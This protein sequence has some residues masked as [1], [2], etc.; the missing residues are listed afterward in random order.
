MKVSIEKGRDLLMRNFGQ[1]AG[2]LAALGI[3]GFGGFGTVAEAAQVPGPA[4]QEVRTVTGMKT[5]GIQRV[6]TISQVYG[7]GEKP[8]AVVL[9]YPAALPAGSLSVQDFSVPGKT[10]TAVYTSDKPELTTKNVSGRYA[11]LWLAQEN[12]VSDQP[13]G[14]KQPKTADGADGK[15]DGNHGRD[16]KDA[17][18]NSN[19]QMPELSL[20]VRQTGMVKAADG[21]IYA[22]MNQE[23]GST[24][25]L[26]PALQGFNLYE[27]TDSKTGYKIP[28][29]LYLPR[30][31]DATKKYPL[32]FFVADASANT[33]NPKMVL[34]Q[35]N[36]AAVWADPVEQA[37]HP[38]IILAPAY[39]QQLV[40]SL[41][42]LTDDSN[43]WT[44]GLT[45]VSDLLFDV[46]DR[47]SV[48]KDRVYGTGQ[49]QGGMTNI[50]ISDKYPELF[51]A[52]YLVAC[53]WNPVEMEALKDKNLWI[54][55][56]QGDTKAYPGMNEAVRR[57]ENLG[58]RVAASNFW[59]SRST[60]AEFAALVKQI[61]DQRAKI[62]YTVFAGGNHMYTWSVAYTIEGIR[63][64]LFAQQ[65]STGQAALNAR[66]VLSKAALDQGIAYYQGKGV[67]QDYSRALAYFQMADRQGNFKAGRYIGLCYENG[68]GVPVDMKKAVEW[69]QKAAA[70]GDITGTC[71]LGHMYED[72]L[73]VERDYSK[74]LQLYMQSARRGDVIAAPGMVSAGRLFEKGLGVAR[75]I[76]LAKVYYIQALSTGYQA[77]QQDL[78]RI[79]NMK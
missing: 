56:C 51:A 27:Y 9:E 40:N 33:D 77:A 54:M 53:Q 47:Y 8:A 10:I 73:G 58:S 5:A 79:Q 34:V 75:D 11:V 17:P 37:K 31:Y 76:T 46:M 20:Q 45:L 62:N 39:T 69:Y 1:R 23:L 64:W 16:G 41:D 44:K 50:A 36:G 15:D 74:A 43:T 38:C 66:G 28:Y 19:R 18:R 72:G 78:L 4:I 22:P 42:M 35:G 6:S 52:Q 29:Y 48:D 24:E 55:V 32:L 59:D 61:E 67:A 30:D 63:D 71:Y 21:T 70:A 60:P 14:Q 7:D 2:V 12:T 57:W 13:L 26:E 65:R 49:S 3:L 25:Q 68:Y